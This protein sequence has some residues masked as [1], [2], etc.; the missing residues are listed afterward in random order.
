MQI[1]DYFQPSLTTNNLST[2]ADLSMVAS[3]VTSSL[4]LVKL[5]LTHPESLYCVV[6]EFYN[7]YT[8]VKSRHEDF[9]NYCFRGLESLPAYLRSTTSPTRTS[10]RGSG[11]WPRSSSSPRLT[12]LSTMPG[13]ALCSGSIF[14]RR[15]GDS[16]PPPPSKLFSSDQPGWRPERLLPVR[17]EAGEAPW[18]PRR[19]GH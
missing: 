9:V 18:R 1:R 19:T 15:S 17:G 10:G 2:G 5:I 4:N 11:R 6:T 8:T 7:L 3:R 16:P 12:F 13:S 14:V